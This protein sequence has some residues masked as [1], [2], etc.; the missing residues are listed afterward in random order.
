MSWGMRKVK[1]GCVCDDDD[2]SHWKKVIGA[3]V[4]MAVTVVL[5]KSDSVNE[6][7]T[8]TVKI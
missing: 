7:E 6:D 3:A 5:K 4:M 8:K 1:G 2:E